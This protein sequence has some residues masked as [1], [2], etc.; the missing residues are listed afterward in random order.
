M[1][2]FSKLGDKINT[3][4]DILT[5]D[6]NVPNVDWTNNSIKKHSICSY[7]KPA[8]KLISLAEELG[9]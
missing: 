8:E 1:G 4:N 5:G 6:F 3:H 2:Q 9:V 7:I